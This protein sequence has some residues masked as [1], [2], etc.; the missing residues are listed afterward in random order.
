MQQC[1][2]IGRLT[3]LHCWR[4]AIQLRRRSLIQTTAVDLLTAWPQAD[5]SGGGGRH[6]GGP[7]RLTPAD[8]RQSGTVSISNGGMQLQSQSM[9]KQVHGWMEVPLLPEM[10]ELSMA[11]WTMQRTS[12]PAASSTAAC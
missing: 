2:Q 5:P 8:C 6:H 4:T 10:Q 3:A 12:S 7:C 1:R 11:A 9:Q